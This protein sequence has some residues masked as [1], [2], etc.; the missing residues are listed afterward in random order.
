MILV[1]SF[2]FGRDKCSILYSNIRGLRTNI[3]RFSVFTGNDIIIL[4][5]ETQVSNMV[6]VRKGP[7]LGSLCPTGYFGLSFDHGRVC[8]RCRTLVSCIR[9]H[10]VSG[11]RKVLV[12]LVPC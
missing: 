4:N 10:S 8:A 3:N 5:S 9:Y 12:S 11:P 6:L 7:S 1:G 2:Y